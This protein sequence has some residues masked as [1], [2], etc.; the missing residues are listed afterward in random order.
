MR[1]W[2]QIYREA[3]IVQKEPAEFVVENIKALRD[4]GVKRILDLG[5]GTGRHLTLLL[6]EGFDVAGLDSSEK[7]I[8]LLKGLAGDGVE[9]RVGDFGKLPW[10]DGSFDAVVCVNV[11][12]HGMMDKI[13]DAASEISRVLKPSG[14]VLLSTLSTKDGGHMV[15]EQVEDNTFITRI[16]PDGDIPHHF[17]TEQELRDLF[18]GF[19]FI[20]LTEDE[21]PVH[22]RQVEKAVL[23]HMMGRKK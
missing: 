14:L 12:Q 21:V 9:L 4:G 7:A 3:G 17:F 10:G 5:C 19:E 23:W 11:I 13:R 18:A 15:G 22:L 20:R 2:D 16:P 6:D 1:D 8:E